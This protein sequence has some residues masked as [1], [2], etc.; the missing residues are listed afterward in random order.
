M[1]HQTT[2]WEDVH[3]FLE[4]YALHDHF[5]LLVF[6]FISSLEVLTISKDAYEWDVDTRLVVGTL[7]LR[8]ITT[9]LHL[10]KIVKPISFTTL[11]DVMDARMHAWIT[12][13]MDGRTLIIF[14]KIT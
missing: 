1:H 8:N 4:R 7:A 10:I 11:V 2:N 5:D 9:S 14:F 12:V 13:L 3:P 6:D